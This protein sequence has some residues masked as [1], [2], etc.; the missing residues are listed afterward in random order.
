MNNENEKKL[1]F[2]DFF[3]TFR[4]NIVGEIIA[5]VLCIVAGAILAF[6][7]RNHYV[8]S[9]EVSITPDLVAS[10]NLSETSAVSITQNYMPTLRKLIKS[11][12]VVKLANDS[13]AA[14]SETAD[15]KCSVGDNRRVQGL[16][17]RIYRRRSTRV[18]LG[19]GQLR[20]DESSEVRSHTH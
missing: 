10:P 20:L 16:R 2:S 19:N 9:A 17:R 3:Y 15:L 6:T 1:N 7:S 18:Q 8:A 11:K 14:S 5:F 12:T 4:K 13:L